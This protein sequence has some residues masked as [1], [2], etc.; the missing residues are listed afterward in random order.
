MGDYL[1]DKQIGK[2]V[3]LLPNGEVETN[4]YYL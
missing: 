2:H 3:S 4:N 1:K